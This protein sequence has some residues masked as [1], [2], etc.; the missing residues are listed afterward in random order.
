MAESP[1]ITQLL[2]EWRRGQAGAENELFELVYP[3]LRRLAHYLMKGER[4]GHTLQ[5]SEL[6]DQAYFRLVRAKDRDWQNRRHFFAIAGRIMRRYL[7][8]YA[9]GKPNAQFLE[10][11]GFENAIAAAEPNLDQAVLIDQLLDRLAGIHPEWC[12]V[13]ELKYFLGMADED[14]AEAMNLK[15]RTMQRIWFEARKWLF[16]QLESGNAAAGK[17]AGR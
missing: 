2:Q 1:E 15:V 3:E 17:S 13:T 6:V 16:E 14:V 8:D 7:I 11:G 10:M 5:P 9:R 4:K 12:T